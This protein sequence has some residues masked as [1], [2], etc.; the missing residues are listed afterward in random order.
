MFPVLFICIYKRQSRSLIHYRPALIEPTEPSSVKIERNIILTTLVS[1]KKGFFL[2]FPPRRIKKGLKN[3]RASNHISAA[4]LR[5][6]KGA[7]VK[8]FSAFQHIPVAVLG[9]SMKFPIS[10]IEKK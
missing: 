4:V 6:L 8:I 10:T 2:N 9:R 1:T 7:A 3:F 5:S